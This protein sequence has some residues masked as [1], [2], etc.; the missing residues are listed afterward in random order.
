MSFDPPIYINCRDRVSTLR[1]LV[2]WLERAG[3]E[4]IVLLDNDSTWEPLIDYLG[5]TPH[6]VVRL[7]E[8]LGCRAL[9]DAGL[10]PDEW[11][12]YSD[13]DLVPIE[14]CP[15]DAVCHLR[16]LAERHGAVKAGLGLYLDDLPASLPCLAWERSLVSEDRLLE[17]GVFSS[18]I[19]TTFAIYRPS[20]AFTPHAIRTGHPYQVRHPSWYL[21]ESQLSDEDRHY[22]AFARSDAS[23]S[24]WAQGQNW[25]SAA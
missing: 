9:W 24:S 1:D 20:A 14:D 8:N 7:G 12:V 4:R 16:E 2:A 22:L 13:P 23:G 21:T 5:A 11:F 15:L 19:D 17:P 6:Q 3:H 25:P 18:L 10:V